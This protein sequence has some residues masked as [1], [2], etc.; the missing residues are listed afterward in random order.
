MGKWYNNTF[1]Q[2]D[3]P[4][5]SPV[6]VY[7]RNAQT[8]ALLADA[9]LTILDS[10]AGS[11]PA[12]DQDLPAGTGT[13]N[14]EKADTLRYHASATADGYTLL[15]PIIFGVP[16]G[17]TTIT[18]TAANTSGEGTVDKVSLEQAR[19]II[20][21]RVDS[22]GVGESQVT[23]TGQNQITVAVP[24]VAPDEL[25]E[26][27]GKVAQLSFRPV[28]AVAPAPVDP[29]ATPEPQPHHRHTTHTPRTLRHPAAK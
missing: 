4:G 11:T 2:T 19:T 9:H 3:D 7:I 27:V 24:N 1:L 25:T 20:Q 5:T 28:Y 22:I 26:M 10:H 14:L 18:L 8:G 6:T 15:S 17:G 12:V 21:Q 23:T 16:E 29:T 13:F